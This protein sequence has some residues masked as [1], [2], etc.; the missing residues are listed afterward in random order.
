MSHSKYTKRGRSLYI[1]NWN[2]SAKKYINTCT[3]CGYKGYSPAIEQNDFCTTAE[4]KAI[5]EE[6]SKTLCKL[7]LDEFGRCNDCARVQNK[8]LS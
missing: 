6:L 3:V 5:Y 2:P 4:N 7:E 1:E 8:F